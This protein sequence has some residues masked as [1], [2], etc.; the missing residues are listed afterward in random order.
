VKFTTLDVTQLVELIALQKKK[1]YRFYATFWAFRWWKVNV[2][3][4]RKKLTR[5]EVSYL[6][7]I[8]FSDFIFDEDTQRYQLNV[9]Q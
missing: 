4:K 6:P 3:T 7:N 8:E 2:K 9:R 1:Q 5:Q